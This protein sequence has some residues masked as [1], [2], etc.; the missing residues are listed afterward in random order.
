MSLLD[1][2][3]NFNKNKLR[4][5]PANEEST[6]V[7]NTNTL[8]ILQGGIIQIRS[9]LGYDDSQDAESVWSDNDDYDIPDY[10]M[11]TM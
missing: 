9:D 8:S 11:E 2:L 4:P 10:Q 3:E 5:T 7:Q 1:E 6:G